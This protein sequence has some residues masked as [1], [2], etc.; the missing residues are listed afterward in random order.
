LASHAFG[1]NESVDTKPLVWIGS[2][3]EDLKK[4]PEA[5]ERLAKA[6]LAH[7]ITDKIQKRH[8]GQPEAA[9]ILGT[10]RPKI[11]A[12]M[13]GKLSGFSLRRTRTS[14]V[15]SA[16][17]GKDSSGQTVY[18]FGKDARGRLIYEPDGRMAVQL[19]NPNRPGFTSNDP[20]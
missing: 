16:G 13:N 5:E 15:N 12:I 19:M 4:F 1:I 8:I 11:S 20:L 6:Q 18:P 7:K 2:G 17:E 9:R 10:E 3:R 14:R